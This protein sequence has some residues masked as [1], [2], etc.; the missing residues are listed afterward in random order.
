MA[1]FADVLKELKQ[2]RRR[3]DR[4]IKVLGTLVGWN[5]ASRVVSIDRKPRRRLS[6]A[7]RRSIARAQ[8]ARWAKWRMR[9]PRKAA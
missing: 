3:L 7:A 4:A 8:R 5:H 1:N 9:Q 6:A 2:E